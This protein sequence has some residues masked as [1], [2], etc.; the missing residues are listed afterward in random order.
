[1]ITLVIKLPIE[2]LTIPKNRCKNMHTPIF[3]QELRAY[4]HLVHVRCV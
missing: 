2:T 4:H 1:M 3:N